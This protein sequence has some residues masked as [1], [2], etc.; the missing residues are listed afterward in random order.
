MN[1][2]RKQI[3]LKEIKYW[4]DHRLLPE[5]YCDFLL[6]LYTEGSEK[7]QKVY[8]RKSFSTK[9]LFS[10]LFMLYLV[11]QL[12][13]TYVV[14]YFT[15][16]SIDLQMT[17]FTIFVMTSFISAFL[18][19]RKKNLFLHVALVVGVLIFF[20]A[21]VHIVSIVFSGAQVALLIII[22]IN[23][24]MWIGSG[25]ILKLKYLIISGV[26]GA[27]ILIAYNLL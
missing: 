25:Y 11:L 19:Y 23:C 2:E 9:R 10:Q 1:K 26:A 16:M 13:F 18:F 5:Q 20:L 3:V 12:P 24:V 27:I 6:S 21:T 8:E 15:E 22:L 17:L 7:E 14:I 4:K